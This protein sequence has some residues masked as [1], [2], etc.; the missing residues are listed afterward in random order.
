LPLE[1]KLPLGVHHDLLDVARKQVP[2]EIRLKTLQKKTQLAGFDPSITNQERLDQSCRKGTAMDSSETHAAGSEAPVPGEGAPKKCPFCAEIIKAEAI[3]CRYCQSDLASRQ[4][5]PAPVAAEY[6]SN[7]TD[8]RENG[9]AYGTLR[10]KPNW[11]NFSGLREEYFEGDYYDFPFYRRNAFIILSL[12]L[13]WPLCL[14]IHLTGPV[15]RRGHGMV[16][17][18]TMVGPLFPMFLMSSGCL[19][20][21]GVSDVLGLLVRLAGV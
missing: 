12:V 20:W 10:P 11:A 4:S 7:A 18:C 8:R 6:D 3:K 5:S 13:F 1:G 9:P 17:E 21:L 14:L 15:Y 16:C 19:L 2:G